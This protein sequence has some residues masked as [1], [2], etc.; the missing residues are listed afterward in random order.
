[1]RAGSILLDCTSS[2]SL[3]VVLALILLCPA[4]RKPSRMLKSFLIWN[5]RSQ[6]EVCADSGCFILVCLAGN[7]E[8]WRVGVLEW[9]E[10]QGGFRER[11]NGE[12]FDCQGKSQALNRTRRSKRSLTTA[13]P[14][15]K[16][17]WHQRQPARQAVNSACST[18][19]RAGFSVDQLMELAGLSVA[20]AVADRF[21]P[22]DSFLNGEAPTVL[23]A[24]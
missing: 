8:P 12:R 3:G 20:S 13:P 5:V 15:Q 24:T 16:T 23:R 10:I 4:C 6:D 21:R 2:L 22:V 9:C 11:C 18:A 17:L 19:Q 14:T 1:M 7:P